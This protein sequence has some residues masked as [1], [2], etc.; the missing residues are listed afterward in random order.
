MAKEKENADLSEEQNSS[1][2]PARR[3]FLQSAAVGVGGLGVGALSLD[4]VSEGAAQ[5]GN[6][7]GSGNNSSGSGNNGG[8][9]VKNG[10]AGDPRSLK[11]TDVRIAVI[12]DIPFPCPIV[13]IYTNQGI[14]GLG[15]ARDFGDPRFI[16]MLKGLL[17][18]RNP[19]DVEQIM[20]DVRRYGDHGR[21]GGGVSAVD[22]ALMDIVGKFYD[23]P[24]HQLIG[25]Q[26]REKVRLYTDTTESQDPETYAE[27]LNDKVD[28]G[29]TALKMNLG[30]GLLADKEGALNNAEVWKNENGDLSQYGYGTD[31][32]TGPTY[33]SA[34]HP[35]TRIQITEK[36]LD[37]LENYVSTVRDVVGYEIPLGIDHFGH[38]GVNEG[39]QLARRFKKYDLSYMENVVAW[40]YTDQWKEFT[41][42]TTVPSM[43]GEDVYALD[44]T[45]LSSGNPRIGFKAL[46]DQDAVDLIHPDIATAGGVNETKRIA[47]YADKNGVAMYLHQAGS[48]IAAMASVHVAAA[49]R[50]FVAQENHA[51]AVDVW[52]DLADLTDTN[53]PMVEDG[54]YNVPE[55]AGLGIELDEKLAKEY[56]QD[57]W[58]W[59]ESTEEWNDFS[60]R[61]YWE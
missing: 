31:P 19:L 22:M 50:N 10:N 17:L 38:F 51:A 40:F 29:Y 56:A 60:T 33:G 25:G 49:S 18:D 23:V 47:D 8:N 7:N 30:I 37:I 27:R 42:S 9:G 3:G 34:E 4:A 28:D 53:K 54:Y 58:G 35:F 1:T 2:S 24:I 39:I 44:P 36:G 6:G 15:E 12:D 57:E 55:G 20:R 13:K 59:F 45:H 16:L 21:A 11:I 5:S 61:Q 43:V 52:R 48:P 14:T 32:K 26:F 41:N 46:I